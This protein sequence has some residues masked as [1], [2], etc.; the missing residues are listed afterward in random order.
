MKN[1]ITLKVRRFP[2]LVYNHNTGREESTAVTVTKDQLRAAKLVGLSTD[3]LIERLL[4]LQG[5]SVIKIG[6]PVKRSITVDLDELLER[7]DTE[8]D[9]KRKW[10]FLYGSGEAGS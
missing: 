6:K 1:E 9:E 10:S 4:D 3:E 2:V 7:Y 8:L 5:F